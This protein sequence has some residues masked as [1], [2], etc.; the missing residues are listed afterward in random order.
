[1]DETSC[2]TTIGDGC[3]DKKILNLV[4]RRKSVGEEACCAAT[5]SKS[6]DTTILASNV[7]HL[8]TELHRHILQY[9][10]SDTVMQY[11]IASKY[12]CAIGTE[13]LFST[14]TFN[15]S[16][17]SVERLI[18]MSKSPDIRRHVKTI[19]W[20]TNHWMIPHVRTF[21]EWDLYLFYKGLHYRAENCGLYT[22]G[23]VLIKLAQSQDEFKAYLDKVRD[24]K[25]AEKLFFTSDALR[26]FQNLQT[27]HISD[28]E[29]LELDALSLRRGEGRNG[30]NNCCGLVAFEFLQKMPPLPIKTLRLEKLS[31]F[32][33]QHV[34]GDFSSL[35]SLDLNITARKDRKH[36]QWWDVTG[37]W[38][39]ARIVP[40]GNLKKF[41][42]GMPHLYSLR[43][44]L[45]DSSRSDCWRGR[46]PLASIDA[47]FG[48]EYTWP[49]LR[50][51]SLCH[52]FATPD[53]LLSLLSRHRATLKEVGLR[54]IF[55]DDDCTQ[56]AANPHW[57]FDYPLSAYEYQ[58]MIEQRLQ[59]GEWPSFLQK[60]AETLHLEQAM[61][62]GRLGTHR[63]GF[64][65]HLNDR[66]LAP[67][68]S[69]YVMSGG[70]CPLNNDSVRLLHDWDEFR[71]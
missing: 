48:S 17:W 1:M 61:I 29:D 31:H 26:R 9:V 14:V 18:E 24:E 30:W 67:A 51:L 22:Y 62:S 23:N 71:H 70:H 65:W 19:I 3:A 36:R 4:A 42:T 49:K 50:H 32:A 64:G 27:I 13:E 11:R 47:V 40:N 28:G 5:L 44:S 43:I 54:N 52:F 20:D 7:R 35:T 60:V 33:L 6:S 12:L 68:V 38:T 21:R 8:P 34:Q 39:A 57:P 15:Y 59:L 2:Q 10:D 58:T 41:I 16:T 55:F 66:D 69:E 46:M 25:A 56:S 53:S 45:H 63:F 37:W